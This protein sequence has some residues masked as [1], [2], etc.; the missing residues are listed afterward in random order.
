MTPI[1]PIPTEAITPAGYPE[2]WPEI[3]FA[4]KE[5]A[6]WHCEHCRAPHDTLSGH[7]LTVHHLNGDKCDC[8]F[9]NLLAACQRCHLH[10]QAIYHP[11]QQ[12]LFGCPHWAAIRN[13]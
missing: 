13:L 1:L 10:I 9:E 2:N 6:A 5:W 8:R 7:V 3:A 11:G 12:W 4:L